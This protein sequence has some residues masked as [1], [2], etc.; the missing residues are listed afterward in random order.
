MLG[1]NQKTILMK[2]DD[3]AGA[4]GALELIWKGGLCYDAGP[5]TVDAAP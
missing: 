2:K 3:A 5:L 4:N 1:E